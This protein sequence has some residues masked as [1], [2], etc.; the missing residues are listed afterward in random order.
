VL[1]GIGAVLNIAYHL[2]TFKECPEAYNEL[3][4]D[5]KVAKADLSRRGVNL[6]A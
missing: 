2:I 6:D 3:L 1:A 5:I 4:E